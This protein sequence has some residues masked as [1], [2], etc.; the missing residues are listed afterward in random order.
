[1]QSKDGS[2]YLTI[3][4]LDKDIVLMLKNLKI[5]EYSQPTEFTD[6]RGKKGI[7]IVYLINKTEPHRENLKDDYSRI[8][9]R[10]LEKR[11]QCIG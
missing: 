1:M 8:A 5:G 9:D 6:E 4:Q 7:R 3:D 10:A 11:R 2:S